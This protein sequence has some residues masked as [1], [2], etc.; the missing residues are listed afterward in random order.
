LV[1]AFLGALILP[2]LLKAASM[3][4]AATWNELE[5]FAPDLGGG[6]A[7]WIE[8]KA[9]CLYNLVGQIGANFGVRILTLAIAAIL[10]PL[11]VGGAARVRWWLLSK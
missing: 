8:Y 5:N 6:A 9:A 11:V 1:L 4:I 2:V 7:R 10:L 3:A